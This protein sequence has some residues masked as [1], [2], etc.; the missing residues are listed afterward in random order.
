[1]ELVIT[2][3]ICMSIVG[4]INILFDIFVMSIKAS[5]KTSSSVRQ[6]IENQATHEALTKEI[7][8]VLAL[9]KVSA[10]I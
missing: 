9:K 3:I 6:K 4:I 1:M 7:N 8:S 5:R 10:D 2:I